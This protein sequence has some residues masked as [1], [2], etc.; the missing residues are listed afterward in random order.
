MLDIENSEVADPTNVIQLTID[1]TS[2]DS[3]TCAILS[4]LLPVTRENIDMQY[5]NHFFDS[6]DKNSFDSMGEELRQR[7]TV[8][9]FDHFQ[10]TIDD[11]T[12]K[13]IQEM[14]SALLKFPNLQ[15]LSLMVLKI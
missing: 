15:I 1:K 10:L 11:N 7:T 13:L 14:V 3:A 5:I 6:N 8:I 4:A 2:L 12:P 9:S